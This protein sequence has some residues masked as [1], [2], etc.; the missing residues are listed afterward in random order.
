[1]ITDS[2][3]ASNLLTRGSLWSFNDQLRDEFPPGPRS[4]FGCLQRALQYNELKIDQILLDWNEPTDS[5]Y[6]WLQVAR[7]LHHIRTVATENL[8]EP[9]T[10]A[11]LAVPAH[12]TDADRQAF[13][14]LAKRI[15]LTILRVRD[16]PHAACFAHEL[17]KRGGEL[18]VTVVDVGAEALRVSVL[19]IDDGV[20]ETLGESYNKTLGGDAYN[21]RILNWLVGID[22]PAG[23]MRRQ[24]QEA[25]VIKY[26]MSK[27]PTLIRSKR[28]PIGEAFEAV[29][30]DLLH[31]SPAFIERVLR[32]AGINKT[33]VESLV[34]TGGSSKIPQVP[35]MI[36]SYFGKKSIV[37]KYGE[38][39]E[40]AARGAAILGGILG[41][42]M[43]DD[44]AYIVNYTTIPLGVETGG[45]IFQEVVP[46]NAIIPAR[47]S[48]EFKV[49]KLQ[50]PDQPVKIRA[51]AGMHALVKDNLLLGELEI[52]QADPGSNFTVRMYW[53]DDDTMGFVV[54][55]SSSMIAEAEISPEN[56]G[57]ITWDRVD[58]VF[59]NFER[60]AA[61]EAGGTPDAKAQV[62]VLQ[63]YIKSVRASLVLDQSG[64][65]KREELEFISET[66]KWVIATESELSLEDV[67]E[68]LGQARAVVEEGQDGLPAVGYQRAVVQYL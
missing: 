67:N 38:P 21:E 13:N 24:L 45:G 54:Y 42:P 65:A 14:D 2:R 52:P 30:H 44:D 55:N 27:S 53:N 39:E 57:R 10:H 8:G 46:R 58:P 4:I 68:K 22:G 23:Q 16:A 36:E 40:A 5:S 43:W 3:G 19:S 50:R 32:S 56:S 66:V 18:N 9:V 41:G 48:K 7:T 34:I 62:E 33:N 15:G 35:A 28:Y 37:L 25:E 12:T 29:A 49:S 60:A 63:Q 1:M 20:F 17:D 59:K 61:T 11:I 47:F 26:A 64:R 6:D 51:Y 31:E